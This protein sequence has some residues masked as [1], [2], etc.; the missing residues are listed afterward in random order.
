MEDNKIIDLFW[1]R[2]EAAITETSAKYTSYC[3]TV[4]WNILFNN[5]DS[6]ECVNDTWYT[7]WKRMPP[8][9]PAI[10]SSFLGRITRGFAIDKIRMKCAG[11]RVD[12]YVISLSDEVEKLNS[13]LTYTLDEQIEE[14]ELKIS[15][16]K[17][18]ISWES[19]MTSVLIPKHYIGQSQK[20]VCL[21]RWKKL[22]WIDLSLLYPISWSRK[23]IQ[24]RILPSI[25][26]PG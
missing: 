1:Q 4:A 11:K 6:E 7:A 14:L 21:L 8:K 18:R 12:S 5:E 24:M 10:L 19:R 17:F 20:M 2:N 23:Q 15:Y 9:R 16:R 25:A 22:H 3:H 13:K 26:K